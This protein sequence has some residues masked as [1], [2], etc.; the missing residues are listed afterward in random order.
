MLGL[1]TENPNNTS[2]RSVVKG[3]NLSSRTTALIQETKGREV[4][5]AEILFTKG[6]E[7]MVQG[8]ILG[9]RGTFQRD[10]GAVEKMSSGTQ[11]RIHLQEQRLQL[12]LACLY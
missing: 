7:S 2:I 9:A 12:A 4:N 11:L 6:T 8:K 1:W 5:A 3:V 10:L